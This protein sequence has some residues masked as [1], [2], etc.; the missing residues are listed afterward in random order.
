MKNIHRLKLA[1][2]AVSGLAL[3]VT[4]TRAFALLKPGG[5]FDWPRWAEIVVG[6]GVLAL[7]AVLLLFLRET[8]HQRGQRDEALRMP[9]FNPVDR[10][11]LGVHRVASRTTHSLAFVLAAAAGFALFGDPSQG[12]PTPVHRARGGSDLLI[13]ARLDGRGVRFSH[14]KHQ[15]MGGGKDSCASCHHMNLPRDRNTACSECHRD[16]FRP[17]AAFPHDWHASPAGGKKTC[18]DCHPAARDRQTAT[19]VRCVKCHNDLIPAGSAIVV[20][21]YAAP[22][23]AFAMHRLCVGCHAEMSA[24]MSGCAWCHKDQRKFQDGLGLPGK[25]AAPVAVLR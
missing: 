10:T 11:W 19:S 24:E 2:W 15:D 4:V 3:S 14:E 25:S 16:L 23:Y 22:G 8:W 7:A 18:V 9:E 5:E 13:D 12:R 1:L 20:K 17:A 21:Q 6:G